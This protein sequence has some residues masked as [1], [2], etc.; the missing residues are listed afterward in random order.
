[1]LVDGQVRGGVVHGIG[2]ALYERM[3][4]DDAAQPLTVNYGDYLMP[5]ATDAPQIEVIHIESPSPFNPLGVKGAGEGGTIPAAACVISAI[6]DAL[7]PLRVTVSELPLS[8]QRIVEL[9]E[10]A[11][12]RSEM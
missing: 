1:M 3:L 8:P 2:N 4:F 11:R 6:E 10:A 7:A 9:I 5:I 12:K